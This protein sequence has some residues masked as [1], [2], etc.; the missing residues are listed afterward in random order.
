MDRRKSLRLKNYDYSKSDY[1][2]VTI[3]PQNNKYPFCKIIS[4]QIYLTDIGN[5][6]DLKWKWL[7]EKHEHLSIDEYVIMPDHF[8][9]ILHILPEIVRDGRDRP[10]QYLKRKPLPQ[11]IG[12][13]KTISSKAIHQAGFYDFNW[14]RSYHERILRENE[15]GI[16]RKYIKLNPLRYQK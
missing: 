16:K 7:F 2:Y 15:I 5:I 14:H 10:L 9:G 8:H 11:L 3:L 4:G 13:F 12:S 6:I 1:Y